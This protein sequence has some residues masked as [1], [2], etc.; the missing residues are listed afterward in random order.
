MFYEVPRFIAPRDRIRSVLWIG[1]IL[2]LSSIASDLSAQ[3]APKS[4]ATTFP[5]VS[6]N[7]PLAAKSPLP[8]PEESAVLLQLPADF[9]ASVFAA[10]P[11]VRNPIDMA[12]DHLGRMWVAENYTY[13]N[14]SLKFRD[15]LR[16]RVVVFTD[17][18]HQGKPEKRDV[19]IDNV[20]KLTSVEVGRGGVWLMCPPRL[21][22]VPDADHDLVPDGPAETVLDGFTVAEQNYHNFANGLRFGP[23][24]WLYGRCGGSCPGNVGRPGTPE[25]DRVSLEGGIWRYH[26]DRQRFEVICHGTTNPWGHDF[27]EI[28]E[29]FFI[30][31]VNGHLWHGIHGAHFKRPFTLDPNLDTY[32]T[33]DQHADHYHFD[34]SGKWTDSRGGAANDFGGG[35]AHSGMMIYQ[36][37]HWPEKYRGSLMTLNFHGRRVNVEHLEPRGTGYVGKH[38]DDFFISGDEWFRGMEISA[39]PDGDVY[40]LDW[41]D[42]GE[43]HEHTGVHRNSGR[44]YKINYES[45]GSPPFRLTIPEYFEDG[46]FNGLVSMQDGED[47]WSSHQSRLYLVD[48]V[49]AGEK[50]S[51]LEDTIESCRSSVLKGKTV[52]QKCRHLWTLAQIDPEFNARDWLF[53]GSPV[54]RGVALRLLTQHWPIDDCY[55]PTADSVRAWPTIRQDAIELIGDFD[56]L[57]LRDAPALRLIVASTLQRLPG[58]LRSDA[59]EKLLQLTADLDVGDHNQPKMIWYGLMSRAAEHPDELLPVLKESLLPGLNEL[60]SRSLGEQVKSSPE[61][62]EK[63]FAIN[64]DAKWNRSV[65]KGLIKGTVGARGLAPPANWETFRSRVTQ[66]DSTIASLCDKFASVFSGQADLDELLAMVGDDRLDVQ[67]RLSALIGSVD[68]WRDQGSDSAAAEKLIQSAKPLVTDARVNLAAARSL[69][70]IPDEAVAKMLLKNLRRFRAPLRPNVVSLLC[71]RIE[72]ADVLIDAIERKQLAKETLTASQVRDIQALADENLTKRLEDV[73][74]KIRETPQDRLDEIERLTSYLTTQRIA[75]ADRSVGRGI[76]D[77]VCANCHKM[78]GQGEKVGPELTGA[79][80]ASL[81]YLLHNMI[82]PDAVVGVDYRAKKI[83]TVDGR[84]LVGLVTERTR[85]TLKLASASRTQTIALD[86]VEQEFATDQ[87]PMPSGLLT[88]MT[89]EDVA[90]LT[91]YLMSPTQVP[92]PSP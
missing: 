49:R 47:R 67:D 58:D 1:A 77:R 26:V 68:Q 36:G 79:Q 16:D 3:T 10:E 74:G 87:S 92:P 50:I 54:I 15:D 55:G 17:E 40:V 83:L 75:E 42:L 57:G 6:D 91:A 59:A 9:H 5:V 53:D 81:D 45:E 8:T 76:Y 4:S 69:S 78:F 90:N 20:S 62:L 29:L 82:D 41:S 30:N 71:S 33:I 35:H 32:E 21:L 66:E 48:Q 51:E 7:E 11:D 43:C 27:N 2:V 37:N 64:R 60:I 39:G 14:R 38:G 63:C 65:M 19:F 80:R 70:S 22:F 86:D 56:K 13:A 28:G 85:R 25:A 73:W 61:L 18:G 84:L 52:P 72:F 23:D 88:T 24:G 46:G 44:I 12:W 34:T 31:T 89:D